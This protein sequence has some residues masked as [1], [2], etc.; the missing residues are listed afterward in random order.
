MVHLRSSAWLTVLSS[1]IRR[2]KIRLWLWALRRLKF[3]Q[4]TP[5][6][7]DTARALTL[8]SETDCSTMKYSPAYRKHNSA[9]KNGGDITLQEITECIRLSTAGT[10]GHNCYGTGAGCA[11]TIK[12]NQSYGTVH[13]CSVQIADGFFH[14]NKPMAYLGFLQLE[15][16]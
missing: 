11:F 9:L 3:N 14:D 15:F 13:F 12:L 7:R 6:K 5:W 2:S 10:R 1:L 4:D 8:G 16:L